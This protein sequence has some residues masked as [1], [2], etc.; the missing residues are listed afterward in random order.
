MGSLN[1]KCGEKPPGHQREQPDAK[2]DLFRGPEAALP[3]W[4]DPPH[5]Q[6]H[7]SL[8]AQA[9]RGASIA[10][11]PSRNPGSHRFRAQHSCVTSSQ[12][13]SSPGSAEPVVTVLETAGNHFVQGCV[14]VHN[15][16]DEILC[17]SNCN[18]EPDCSLWVE[19]M[20]SG[21]TPRFGDS[22]GKAHPG[23]GA[24]RARQVPLL[25]TGHQACTSAP[26]PRPCPSRNVCRNMELHRVVVPGLQRKRPRSRREVSDPALPN[27]GTPGCRPHTLL[28]PP[29]MGFFPVGN[30]GAASHLGLSSANTQLSRVLEGA[31]ERGEAREECRQTAQSR[32]PAKDNAVKPPSHRD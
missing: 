1:L 10:T 24:N 27:R 11:L 23:Q 32:P 8:T 7:L 26:P 29:L 19:E 28:P 2:G 14:C 18:T 20:R 30:L 3:Q 16:L 13:Q 4:P 12:R 21:F 25:Q 15:D 5:V 17:H 9:G 22:T 6:S 31:A